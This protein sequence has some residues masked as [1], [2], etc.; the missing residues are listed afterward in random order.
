M[1]ES[2][3]GPD[4]PRRSGWFA[5]LATALCLT[6]VALLAA[7][8]GEPQPGSPAGLTATPDTT[9]TDTPIPTAGSAPAATARS[10][11]QTASPSAAAGAQPSEPDTT[12]TDTPVPTAGSAP[13]ATVHSSTQGASSTSAAEAPPSTTVEPGDADDAPRLDTVTPG[14]DREGS[15]DATAPG[16]PEPNPDDDTAPHSELGPLG[17]AQRAEQ[18]TGPLLYVD[19][20]LARPTVTAEVD[21]SSIFFMAEDAKGYNRTVVELEGIGLWEAATP[22]D[23][24]YIDVFVVPAPALE[25]VRWR[26]AAAI[27]PEDAG[28]RYRIGPW[29]DWSVLGVPQV[30]PPHAGVDREEQSLAGTSWTLLS[31]G[32]GPA[33]GNVEV[34]FSAGSRI[35]GWTG[36]NSYDG[37]YRASGPSFTIEELHW[38][39]AGCPSHE[40]F[41]QESL[42]LDLLVDAEEFA[43]SGPRLTITSSAGRTITFAPRQ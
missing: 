8:G 27:A 4:R 13:A 7:C 10:S 18:L 20:E 32:G 22:E 21:G 26:V 39:E 6:A 23:G 12:G 31:V 9:G 34:E 30:V 37:R 2:A 41:L 43:I 28:G 19:A 15:G 14:E 35:S 11:T 40:M 1:C 33:V 3:T 25:T 5:V 36:C 42:Y 16:T 38:T 24:D 17:R 29:T